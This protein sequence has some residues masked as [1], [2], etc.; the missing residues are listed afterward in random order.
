M[1][2]VFFIIVCLLLCACHQKSS[3]DYI[4]LTKMSTTAIYS[5]VSLLMEEA[6]DYEGV[7]IKMKGTF[8][9][10]EREDTT[11]NYYYCFIADAAGCCSQGIEFLC[12]DEVAYPPIGTD[13]V[14]EGIYTLYWENDID[15]YRIDH[16]N[17]TVLN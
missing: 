13:I 14:V 8:D 11:N 6:E 3:H 2:K 10:Y 9:V 4:D 16:A 7:R 15:Y 5:Q 1:R 17:M 12:D